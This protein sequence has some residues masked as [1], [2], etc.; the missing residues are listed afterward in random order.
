M[1][2]EGAVFVVFDRHLALGIRAN[3]GQFAALSQT[4]VIFHEPMGQIDRQRHERMCFVAGE[5]KHHALVAGAADIDA[6][7]DVRR[8]AV[9]MAL[10][11]TGVRC[12]ANASD[13][14]SRFRGWRRA[15]D[16]STTERVRLACV[17]ISPETMAKS[18]VTIVSQAT[19][20]CGSAARQ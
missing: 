6:G 5:A 1:R 20:L 14:R 15:P 16:R 17:V 11:L 10:H 12:E 19:R 18:V 3:E 7:G 9:Q 8:L 4:S 13:R 2:C